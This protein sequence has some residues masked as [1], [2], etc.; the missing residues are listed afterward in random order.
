[1]GEGE[2]M[3]IVPLSSNPVIV[4]D[5]DGTLA[6]TAPDLVATLNVLLKRE[7]LATLAFEEARFG[8]GVSDLTK[9]IK[10]IASWKA[11]KNIKIPSL[12][13]AVTD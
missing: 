8:H 11:G 13:Y 9:K 5:L 4:F 1:M 6:D 2:P 3:T 7:G 10:M 12:D